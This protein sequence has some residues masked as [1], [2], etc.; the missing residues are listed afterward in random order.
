MTSYQCS[1]CPK[2]ILDLCETTRKENKE[3]QQINNPDDCT[4]DSINIC[5]Y[6]D[7][8]ICDECYNTAEHQDDLHI[9]YVDSEDVCIKCL[10]TKPIC[11]SCHE[12]NPNKQENSDK[13]EVCEVCKRNVCSACLKTVDNLH[14]TAKKSLC[15]SCGDDWNQRNIGIRLGEW[16]RT[17]YV[18]FHEGCTRTIG[19]AGCG[20]E[21]CLDHH[22]KSLHNCTNIDC[23][24]RYFQPSYCAKCVGNS[25]ENEGYCSCCAHNN[26][27][28]KMNLV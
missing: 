9:A 17:E 11:V 13:L 8:F 26:N 20:R 12:I 5:K 10:K 28:V 15:S 6:C 27:I 18:W 24:E 21:W 23:T 25:Y 4:C 22:F 1:V 3:C 7:Y 16:Y 19:C 14:F 2:I